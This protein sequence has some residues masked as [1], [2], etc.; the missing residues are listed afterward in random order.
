MISILLFRAYL[1]GIPIFIIPSLQNAKHGL[2]KYKFFYTHFAV[3]TKQANFLWRYLFRT[4]RIFW[5][6]DAKHV[7]FKVPA[8]LFF[9]FYTKKKKSKTQKKKKINTSSVTH[10]TTCI[11]YFLFATS[12]SARTFYLTL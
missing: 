11:F 10:F 3:G 8:S 4:I 2:I 1:F 12:S 5:R 9:F 7:F 6:K